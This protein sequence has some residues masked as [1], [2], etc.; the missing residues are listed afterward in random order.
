[1]SKLMD[2]NEEIKKLDIPAGLYEHCIDELKLELDMLYHPDMYI[3]TITPEGESIREYILEYHHNK[4][5]D[6]VWTS[7]SRY[8]Y[9][10]YS[11]TYEG[12]IY[13]VILVNND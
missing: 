10:S 2:V 3:L 1:M 6:L 8:G 9:A 11:I 5:G 7:I 4:K 12:D 13:N